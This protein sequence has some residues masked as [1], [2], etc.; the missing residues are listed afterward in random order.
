MARGR[1]LVIDDELDLIE[2]VRYNLEKEGFTVQGA[3]D[4]ESGLAQAIRELPDLIV[5]DLM[6]PGVDGLDVCRS[7]RFDKRT[8]RIPIIMLTAKSEESDRI[9]GLELGADDYVTKPF[10]PR[11]LV[12]RIKAVLRRTSAPQAESE[13]IQRGS[14]IIDL[15]RRAVS[16]A[17]DSI[18]LTAT[19]FRLLQFFATRPGRV[20]SR[21]ELIDGVLGR[22]VVVEDRTIDVHITGLRKKLGGCGDWI[23]TVRGFGYRFR[24]E[25]ELP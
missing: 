21:S 9:L 8:A 4:G 11:E 3:Q 10:S 25:S 22:D 19:E 1:I 15:T 6:L 13:I 16:C 20:F 24:E 7:L 23:E 12:A 17:G 2:L 14:L 18:S 5:V